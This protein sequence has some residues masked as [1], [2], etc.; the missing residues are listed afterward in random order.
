MGQPRGDSLEVCLSDG[1]T[2]RTIQYR[3]RHTSLLAHLAQETS[4]FLKKKSRVATT[5]LLGRNMQARGTNKISRYV[6]HTW[7]HADLKLV[8][9]QC[10]TS[11][12]K[13]NE[14]TK[15][16]LKRPCAVCFS[17]GGTATS[18]GHGL[19]DLCAGS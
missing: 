17:S 18:A 3:S 15:K 8:S 2:E 5:L 4:F 6:N 1:N 10:N 19:R 12:L 13:K 11:V 9:Q 14:A 7:K 16:H